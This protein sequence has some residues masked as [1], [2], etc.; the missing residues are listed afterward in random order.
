MDSSIDAIEQVGIDETGVGACGRASN[1]VLTLTWREGLGD[2]PRRR[3]TKM[4]TVKELA[5]LAGVSVRTLHHYDT[6]GLLKPAHIG[7]NRYRYYGREELLR[8]QQILLHR[9]LGMALD[10]IGAVLDAPEFDRLKALEMQRERIQAEIGR[11]SE[12]LGTISRTIASLKGVHEMDDKDLYS[13]LVSPEKQA[14]Y[15]AWLVERFGEGVRSSPPNGEAP[16]AD[17]DA[18]M[19]ELEKIERRLADLKRRG[20]AVDDPKVASAVE[21]HRRWLEKM[22]GAILHAGGLC[23][24]RRRLCE[25]SR[26]R[27]SLRAYRTRLCRLSRTGDEDLGVTYDDQG[28]RYDAA[29]LGLMGNSAGSS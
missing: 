19:A 5:V 10:E 21:A 26:F 29:T 16:K 27:G 22:W 9:R 28:G 25:P 3:V 12:I 8:L 6:V 13:G 11:F 14:E 15:D 24:A 2:Y 1:P 20:V 4:Y 7:V 17:K 23:R 18:S